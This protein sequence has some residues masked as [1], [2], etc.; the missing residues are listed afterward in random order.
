MLRSHEEF[1]LPS[2]I[3]DQLVS[4]VPGVLLKVLVLH[5]VEDGVADRLLGQRRLVLEQESLI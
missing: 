2:D 1:F 3:F 5:H 4:D